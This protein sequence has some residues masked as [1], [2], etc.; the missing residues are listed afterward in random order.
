MKFITTTLLSL[1]ILGIGIGGYVL[2]GK[3]PK[4]AQVEENTDTSPLVQTTTIT[5]HEL[6]VVI[7]M[8]GDANSLRVITVA[9]QVRGQITQRSLKSRSGMF[10][11]KGD[12]L[13]EIDSTNYRLELESLEAQKSQTD[14]EIT[15]VKVDIANTEE[16]IELA[17]ED[18]ILQKKQLRRIRDAYARKSAS[19]SDVDSVARQEITARN[20]LQTLQNSKR[21]MKQ[22]LKQ[23]AASRKLVVAEIKQAQVNVERCHVMAPVTGR[24]VDDIAEQGDYVRDG[25]DLVH[26]S[27]SSQ[28]EVKSNLQA[29]DL[30]W[31]LQKASESAEST[32]AM[33]ANPLATP[34]PCEIIYDFEGT[35]V[36][37]DGVLSR[38]EGTGMDRDTRTFPCRITVAEPSRYRVRAAQGLHTAFAPSLLS[39]MFVTVRIPITAS[40]KLLSIPTKAIRPGGEV[41]VVRNGVLHVRKVS[42]ARSTDDHALIRADK[43]DL[44]ETDQVVISPLVSVKDGMNVRQEIV[45]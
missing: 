3:P 9:A 36:L 27:D 5:H 30:V 17:E 2:F 32:E 41:W 45:E 26:I 6:P 11:H 24:I 25:D 12:V 35:E 37:W 14:E 23:K 31:I 13:F 33:R 10:V 22:L 39:G 29:D 1:I 15:S 28:I 19:E 40:N 8:D 18:A 4:V 7:E 34:I 44:T 21:S 38:F 20:A 43:T 42:L 16:L